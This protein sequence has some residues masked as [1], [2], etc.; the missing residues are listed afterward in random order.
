MF[1]ES[2]ERKNAGADDADIYFEDATSGMLA[3]LM[4][5]QIFVGRQS[6]YTYV[7]SISGMRLHVTSESLTVRTVMTRRTILAT[8]AL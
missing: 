7:H 3:G 8:H 6:T 5:L 2:R 4:T 1:D